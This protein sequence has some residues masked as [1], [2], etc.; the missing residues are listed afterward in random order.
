MIQWFVIHFVN[1]IVSKG[2]W[3]FLQWLVVTW[4]VAF[5]PVLST[6]CFQECQQR[7]PGIWSR[8]FLWKI[9]WS[10]LRT[11]Q[12][13]NA[14]NWRKEPWPEWLKM[15]TAL[16]CAQAIWGTGFQSFKRSKVSIVAVAD[17]QQIVYIMDEI[18]QPTVT[19]RETFQAL[20]CSAPLS[21][22]YT[23]VDRSVKR[24]ISLSIYL[25]ICLSVCLSFYLSIYLP[26]YLYTYISTYLSKYLSIYLPTYLLS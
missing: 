6:E 25:P 22:W 21:L 2:A 7:L 23:S 24:S 11:K 26:T 12:K 3:T 18:R 20:S 14:S 16:V 8:R 13:V 5:G 9:H 19:P 1:E 15:F 17:G 4:I 10:M